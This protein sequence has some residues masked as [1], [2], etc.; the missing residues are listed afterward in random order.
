[1]QRSI[2]MQ[3]V[4]YNNGNVVSENE[5]QALECVANVKPKIIN[6]PTTTKKTLPHSVH[7]VKCLLSYSSKIKIKSTRN[8]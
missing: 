2:S 1:M 4:K 8:M 7:S 5:Q 6:V 3:I